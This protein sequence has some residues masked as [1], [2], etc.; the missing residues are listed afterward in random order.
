M[1]ENA[2][3]R[4]VFWRA[5]CVT[6]GAR[7]VR[8][9]ATR[10]RPPKDGTA[11]V[12]YFHRDDSRQKTMTLEAD[13]FIRRFLI[14]VLPDRF[15]RIRYFGF[16]SNCHRA[17]KLALCRKLLGMATAEPA[18]DP[19]ADYR[20]RFEALTGQIECRMARIGVLGVVDVD[21]GDPDFF[22]YSFAGLYCGFDSQSSQLGID[23]GG[24]QCSLRGFVRVGDDNAGNVSTCGS[25]DGIVQYRCGIRNNV[26]SSG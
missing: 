25:D 7:P 20:D 24:C 2:E 13:E 15:H 12:A 6:K 19:P 16:L 26:I 4:H 1:D 8:E 3:L 11:L 18:A 21:G 9:E 22:A 10:D 5:G 23:K 14:H 17:Q